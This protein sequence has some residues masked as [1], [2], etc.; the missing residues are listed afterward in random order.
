MNP[1]K[2]I[3]VSKGLKGLYMLS[4]KFKFI[5]EDDE[6][7][8]DMYSGSGSGQE[9]EVEAD[10]HHTDL[11]TQHHEGQHHAKHC[12]ATTKFQVRLLLSFLF[13]SL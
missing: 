11:Q 6:D 12:Q 1:Q 13:N 9:E 7:Y 3:P 8:M 10:F 4:G 5:L 2:S